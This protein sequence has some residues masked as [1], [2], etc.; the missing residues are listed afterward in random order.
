MTGIFPARSGLGSSSAFTVGLLHALYA[1][2]GKMTTKRRLML[3][4]IYVEQEMI[5]ESVG[6][7]D[8]AL[9]AFGG[10]NRIDFSGNHNIEVRPITLNL[11]RLEELQSHLMLFFTHI[12]RTASDIAADKISQIPNK[13]NELRMLHNMVKEAIMILNEDRDITEFGKLLHEAWE[14]KRKLSLKVSNN[15]ID[16]I[17]RKARKAGAVGGKILGAGGGGFIIF[18][19]KPELQPK[20]KEALKDLLYVPFRFDTLGSQIIY[21]GPDQYIQ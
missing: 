15:T 9:T 17:Y 11:L 4:A 21:Y 3:D 20:V 6:S 16:D 12:T 2:Q 13:K 8:Q 7:Q 18:F 14:I 1:L 19:V 5:K 10:F